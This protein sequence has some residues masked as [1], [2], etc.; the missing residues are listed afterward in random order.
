MKTP[1]ECR[2]VN[3][4]SRRASV[5][6]D[7]EKSMSMRKRRS[8]VLRLTWAA[9][10]T[11]IGL[12]LVIVLQA[13]CKRSTTVVGPKGGK[14]AISKGGKDSELAY[15]GMNGEEVHFAGG[16]QAVALPVDFPADVALY[17]KAMPVR[18]AT[19]DKETRVDLTTAASARDVEA[20]YA[21]MLKKDGWQIDSAI[22]VPHYLKATKRG[23]TLSV[24]IATQSGESTIHLCMVKGK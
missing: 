2:G 3:A 11:A 21:R 16:K 23:R 24:D 14:T 1:I 19:S 22:T 12:S 8:I 7:R 20:F 5:H 10:C 17:P 15:K 9:V 6:P 18:T 13:G 4:A